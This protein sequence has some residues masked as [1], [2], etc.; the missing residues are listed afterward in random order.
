M[1]AKTEQELIAVLE[2]GAEAAVR[3]AKEGHVYELTLVDVER[4]GTLRVRVRPTP[5]SVE[6]DV[7]GEGLVILA[8]AVHNAR[9]DGPKASR[10]N[11]PKDHLA[12]VQRIVEARIG[13]G[14]CVFVS[15]S[16]ASSSAVVAATRR[17]A[18]KLVQL[19]L[20]S[21]R[22]LVILHGKTNHVAVLGILGTA[23]YEGSDVF[24]STIGRAMEPDSPAKSRKETLRTLFEGGAWA[25]KRDA[26]TWPTEIQ[27]AIQPPTTIAVQTAR[28]DAAAWVRA[29]ARAAEA[30]VLILAVYDAGHAEKILRAEIEWRYLWDG[31]AVENALKDVRAAPGPLIFA[32]HDG[33]A[34]LLRLALR[35]LYDLGLMRDAAALVIVADEQSQ[36]I[37]STSLLYLLGDWHALRR[38]EIGRS[39]RG[40]LRGLRKTSKDKGTVH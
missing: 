34:K 27:I 20:A 14:P 18:E 12:N 31:L 13:V 22:T 29:E 2:G 3:A 28:E 37:Q 7:A 10:L 36:Q 38:R 19:K 33:E 35:A 15:A 1:G 32:L 25:V 30:R 21:A 6:L 23:M 4:H 8:T 26:G 5:I 11:L 40:G 24:V 16:A 39:G 9:R 17:I